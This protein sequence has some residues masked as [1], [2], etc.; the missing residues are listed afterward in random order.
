MVRAASKPSIKGVWR[1]MKISLYMLLVQLKSPRGVIRR[2]VKE[3]VLIHGFLSVGGLICEK[4][5]RAFF[6]NATGAEFDV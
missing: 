5:A 4:V 1:S 2:V 3:K 6:T